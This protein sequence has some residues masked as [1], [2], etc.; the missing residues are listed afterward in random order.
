LVRCLLIIDPSFRRR[1][2]VSLLAALEHIDEFMERITKDTPSLTSELVEK[3]L[4]ELTFTGNYLSD[5]IEW[6]KR[7]GE[8]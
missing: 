7:E 6:K 1:R 3:I 2:D 8:A 4:C 5:Y